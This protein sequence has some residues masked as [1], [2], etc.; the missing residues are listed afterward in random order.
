M[1]LQWRKWRNFAIHVADMP[2]LREFCFIIMDMVC[3][4]QLLMVK[5]GSLIGFVTAFKLF[6]F[7][8]FLVWCCLLCI[9]KR[10]PWF[11]W[12]K[13]MLQS[14]TQYIPLQIS[15][16][17][18]WLKTPSIYVFDCSASGMIINA[19]N[20]VATSVLLILLCGN[21]VFMM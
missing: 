18:S 17:D 1:I 15:D 12:P 16:L 13:L 10:L 5:F 2:N 19:F 14:Y 7:Y 20:E 8:L 4:N 21:L 6:T 11:F 9:L 3:Q